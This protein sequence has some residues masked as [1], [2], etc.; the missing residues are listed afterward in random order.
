LTLEAEAGATRLATRW[1]LELI[2]WDLTIAVDAVA[3]GALALANSH[4]T[5]LST[6]V[7]ASM[8]A[9]AQERRCW[10]LVHWLAFIVFLPDSSGSVHRNR[11]PYCATEDAFK[12]L[13]QL[14]SVLKR[15]EK[16]RLPGRD[17]A[18]QPKD[19]RA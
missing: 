19:S 9:A 5:L 3:V 10:G 14:K 2:G 16:R 17:G 13:S 15:S 18:D 1:V 12:S 11:W 4:S 8:A 6:R 7:E